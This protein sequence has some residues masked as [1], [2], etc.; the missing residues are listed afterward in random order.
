MIS[1]LSLMLRPNPAVPSLSLHWLRRQTLR[2]LMLLPALCTLMSLEL[3]CLVLGSIL[4]LESLPECRRWGCLGRLHSL[5]LGRSSCPWCSAAWLALAASSNPAAPLPTQGP[6]A[7][8]GLAQAV[9]DHAAGVRRSLALR[10]WEDAGLPDS[11]VSQSL[12][13]QMALSWLSNSLTRLLL[14]PGALLFS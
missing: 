14:P 10:L 11:P 6:A 7:E 9:R 5:L 13:W 12:E 1:L 4:L 8:G 2:S 3:C